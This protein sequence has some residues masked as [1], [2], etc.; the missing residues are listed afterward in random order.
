MSKELLS[1][2]AATQE[3]IERNCR[4][5]SACGRPYLKAAFTGQ[6]VPQVATDEPA[7]T[8]LA[9][10]AADPPA[11]PPPRRSRRGV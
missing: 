3:G 6:L 7:S 9:R 2:A 4:P 1:Q 8:L 11:S 5:Q 10:I